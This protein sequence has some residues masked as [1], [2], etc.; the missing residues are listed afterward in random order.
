MASPMKTEETTTEN[1]GSVAPTPVKTEAPPMN[2]EE[3]PSA[4]KPRKDDDERVARAAK[5]MLKSGILSVPQAML[6]SDFNSDESRDR[7]LQQRVRRLHS[8]IEKGIVNPDTL[9]DVE[10]EFEDNIPLADKAREFLTQSTDP[11]VATKVCS[12]ALDAAGFVKLSKREAFGGKLVPGGS[13]YY[14]TNHSTVVAFTVGAKFKPGNGFKIIGGHTDSPHLKI[15]PLSKRSGAGCVQL[16]VECYGGG[17]WHT[18]FDRDLGVSGRVLVRVTDPET[19]KEKIQQ[20]IICIKKPI[21][22]VSTL[23]IHLQTAEERGAF[24]VNKEEHLSPIIGTQALLEAAVG[25]QINQFDDEDSWKKGQDP[26]LMKLIANEIGVEVKQ[27]ANFELG[28]FDCQPA[29]LGG[30]KNE[31]LYSARLDNLATVFVALETILDY[32]QSPDV[33][34]DDM[35][36]LI[37]CFDH[38]EI[39]STSTSGAGSPVMSEAVER[40]TAAFSENPHGRDP[41]T[42]SSAV[43]KSFI[44][45]VDQAH[46]LHPNYAGK[47]EK[48]HGPKMN[49]G[50]VIKTNQNQRYA[51]N[52]VTGFF[53]RELARKEPKVPIQE[54][55]VRSDCPCGSTIGPILSASTG[56]RTVDLGMPQL[57]MHSCR[58]VMGI[59]DL[60]HCLN[61]FKSF[62]KNFNE[63]DNCIEG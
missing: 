7:A 17:L 31:F 48:S 51:T 32:S 21:A 35:I 56:I 60:T 24:K 27:I 28:L 15:K 10:K 50:I 3:L 5:L 38:E 44:F 20:H 34:E 41:E 53:A 12:E 30:M 16:G 55:V 36:S 57:S 42:H 33:A 13:Y 62:F 19:Q 18:W 43:R 25:K 2:A 6:C 47:H 61:L 1:G 14:T 23:C 54:F 49:G 4:K 37:A 8:K 22:R 40:I 29:S 9:Q 11:F 59:A 26:S 63:L 45:S 58:E 46:A 52:G 39:G